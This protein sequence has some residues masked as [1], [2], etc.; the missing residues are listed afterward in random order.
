MVTGVARWISIGRVLFPRFAV[1]FRHLVLRGKFPDYFSFYF[2]I[3]I[4]PL[5]FCFELSWFI[6]WKMLLFLI[7]TAHN[8]D[9]CSS[10]STHD[11]IYSE[12]MG[13]IG[14]LMLDNSRNVGILKFL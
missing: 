9:T 12:C 4:D 6:G 7:K 8:A 3:E 2:N 1:L 10:S 14:I 5:G 13:K 11:K